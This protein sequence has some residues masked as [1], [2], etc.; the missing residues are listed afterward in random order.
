MSFSSI[1]LHCRLALPSAFRAVTKFPQAVLSLGSHSME[2]QLWPRSSCSTSAFLHHV[3]LFVV[4]CIV[5]LVVVIVLFF[6]VVVVVVVGFF[7][8]RPFSCSLQVSSGLQFLRWSRLP[9]RAHG[10]SISS[11]FVVVFC[12]CCLFVFC[13][14]G[15]QVVLAAV[16]EQICP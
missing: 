13:D 16:V 4:L 3:L 5:L 14:Q 11:V 12:C 1:L 6:V 7:G 8:G 10:R 15:A 9:Y 2:P